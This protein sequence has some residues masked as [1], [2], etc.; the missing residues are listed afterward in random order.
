MSLDSIKQKE[1]SNQSMKSLEEDQKL[2]VKAYL[3]PEWP[4]S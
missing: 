1:G 2:K 3:S 4:S